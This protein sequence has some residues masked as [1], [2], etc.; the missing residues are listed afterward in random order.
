MTDLTYR[1]PPPPPYRNGGLGAP[2]TD[3]QVGLLNRVRNERGYPPVTD[4]ELEV[5]DRRGTAWEIHET[6]KIE[7]LSRRKSGQVIKAGDG[8]Y[9]LPDGSCWEVGQHGFGGYAFVR[10]LVR[11]DGRWRT[12]PITPVR[13]FLAAFQICEDIVGCRER[14]RRMSVQQS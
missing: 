11:E 6:L 13:G 4:D 7:P 8:R 2:P 14:F 9:A 5:M 3:A 12:Q 1:R 10:R